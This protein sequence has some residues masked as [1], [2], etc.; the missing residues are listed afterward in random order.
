MKNT[1]ETKEQLLKEL[2]ELR[3]R[4]SELEG[5][6]IGYKQ[7]KATLKESESKLQLIGENTIEF[8][9]IIGLDRKY[10]YASPSYKQLG[11]DPDAL[12]G[13]DG[14]EILHPDDRERLLLMFTQVVSGIFKTGD[15]KRIEARVRNQSGEYHHV[16]T[17]ARL[18]KDASGQFQILS[19]VRDITERK[20]AEQVSQ[21]RTEDLALV[22]T[23][24]AA[25][26]RGDS[27][28]EIIE[29][30]AKGIKR[31][32]SSNAATIYLTS[33]DKGY[34]VL[35][36]FVMATAIKKGVEKIIG[37]RIPE[38]HIPLNNGSITQKLLQAGKPRLMNSP[39]EIQAWMLEFTE[40][41]LLS[42][43]LR[44]GFK[45]LIPKIYQ[46]LGIHSVITVP[47]FLGEEPV[48]LLDISRCEPF[49]EADMQRVA[50]IA[51]QLSS[52]IQRIRSEYALQKSEV[53]FRLLADH[54]FDWEYWINPQGE[55]LYIS[56]A[57][58]RITGYSPEEFNANPKL[59]FEI[60][61][62]EHKA[63]V[64]THYQEENH[65]ESP[66]HS[67]EFQIQTRDGLERWV[68]HNCIP[69]FDEE[70]NFSGRR[71]NNRDITERIQAQQNIQ[72]QI[73]RLDA[74]RKID[75]AITGSLDLKVTLNVILDHVLTQLTV[76]AATVLIYEET[77]QSLTFVQGQGLRTSALQYTNLRLG[78]GCAGQAALQRQP[79]FIPDLSQ[80]PGCFSESPTIKDEAFVAYYGLPLIAKG[81]LVGVLEIFNRSPLEQDD[82]WVNFLKTLAGQAAITIDNI[83]LFEGLQRSNMMLKQAYDATIEGWAQALELR[84]ME[85]E[86]HS[87]RVV[88]IAM[89]LAQILGIGDEQLVHF[90]RGALLHDIGKMGIPDAILQKPGKLTEE[91]WGIMR[92]HPIYAYKWLSSIEY[93]RPALE[94]P[95]YHHERWDGTGYPDGL[96]GERIPFAARIFAIVDVW[97][98]LRSER[99]YRKAWSKEK[100]M[101]HIQV[102]SG[103][104]FDP[105]V[106]E[107]F[108]EYIRSF[109]S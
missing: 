73:S 40:T 7:T 28:P 12:I 11:Y 26:N 105:Q 16:E 55:Y 22:N 92:K 21:K 103:K 97:D 79:V 65:S 6:E 18:F 31:I 106:V 86:G 50:G 63:M 53:T 82:A 8:V 45:A 104:H 37:T 39:E 23:I 41:P 108:L 13:R 27:L 80:A 107:T 101:A 84:D 10:I 89:D 2:T 77:T 74:L 98:A 52:A 42:N 5:V 19:V 88:K 33:D 1:P 44:R 69:I 78:E 70:G 93:L 83:N 35:Q 81:S 3:Q 87:R 56:P 67:M 99:P 49:T 71:G 91:E 90:R 24:N 9:S 72:K 60:V 14:F 51:G 57:C 68:A 20:Q 4:V 48:G 75:R 64:Q 62:P 47:L 102:E 43:N 109:S 85:T 61:K 34:L 58:E 29:L 15:I 66:T 96:K 94:I 100:T 32:L 76:D 17:V 38:V 46:I 54:T 30:V 95:H 25:V 36:S 59:L